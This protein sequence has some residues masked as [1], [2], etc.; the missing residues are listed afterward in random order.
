MFNVEPIATL[1]AGSIQPVHLPNPF[2]AQQFHNSRILYASRAS[3]AVPCALYQSRQCIHRL[4]VVAADEDVSL[5]PFRVGGGRKVLLESGLV[6]MRP[7][8]LCR[9]S[10]QRRHILLHRTDLAPLTLVDQIPYIGE[11]DN[12]FALQMWLKRPQCFV[13]I[14]ERCLYGPEDDIC[15]GSSVSVRGGDGIHISQLFLDFFNRLSG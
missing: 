11:I 1:L 9:G 14:C 8:D 4:G 12:D 10:S 2:G 7:L 3:D 5:I 13:S 15:L 6:S